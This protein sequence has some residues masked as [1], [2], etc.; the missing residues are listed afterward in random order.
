M[1]L[2]HPLFGILAIAAG[3]LLCGALASLVSPNEK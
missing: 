1:N 2:N 3:L